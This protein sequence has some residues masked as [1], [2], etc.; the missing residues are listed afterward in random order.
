VGYNS[1]VREHFLKYIWNREL[2]KTTFQIIKSILQAIIHKIK[3]N[4]KINHKLEEIA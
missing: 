4:L 1:K 2:V 3:D